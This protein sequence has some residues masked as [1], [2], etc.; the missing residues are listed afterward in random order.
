MAIDQTAVRRNWASRYVNQMEAFMTAYEKLI[1]LENQA[2]Q[3]GYVFVDADFAGTAL[4]H[5]DAATV[6]SARTVMT[7]L[8]TSGFE[9]G[10]PPRVNT[11]Q[12]LRP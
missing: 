2:A 5:L 6:A 4:A 1:D 7:A 3:A 9:G 8:K 10:T 11:L 12:K